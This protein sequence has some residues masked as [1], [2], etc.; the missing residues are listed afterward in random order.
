MNEKRK[1]NILDLPLNSCC[2]AT[3]FFG[4]E[5]G[6]PATEMGSTDRRAWGTTSIASPAMQPQ[7]K[8][9]HGSARISGLKKSESVLG[10]A[11]YNTLRDMYHL[12][13]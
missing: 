6:L 7:S 8:A 4:K 2:L 3:A 11:E 13:V 5:G 10:T 12:T 9:G 1:S